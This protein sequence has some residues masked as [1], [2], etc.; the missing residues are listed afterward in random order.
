MNVATT[1]ET[2]WCTGCRCFLPLED[3]WAPQA[4][5]CRECHA[6]GVRR[7][8]AANPDAVA[9]YNAERR[10]GPI[11]KTCIGC[12]AAFEAR[13]TLQARCPECQ[14]R[15]RCERKR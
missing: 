14:R 1:S 5:Q 9:E 6:E 10:R 4:S 3:F 12:G 15:H 13:S 8:R 2:R 11:M 7:W